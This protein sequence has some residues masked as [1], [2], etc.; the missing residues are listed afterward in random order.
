MVVTAPIKIAMMVASAAISAAGAISQGRAAN[1]AA[2]FRARQLEQQGERDRQLAALQANDLRDAESRTQAS[3]RARVG[4]GGTTLEG[5]PLAILSDLAGETELQARRVA[6]GG[7]TAANRAQGE[8]AL[9]RFEGKN[10]QRA[11]VIKAGSSLL[12]S[13]SSGFGKISS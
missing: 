10:A 13:A 12:T 1:Q 4:G 11:G 2:K 8:A 5:T 9:R 3:L 7:E 6:V